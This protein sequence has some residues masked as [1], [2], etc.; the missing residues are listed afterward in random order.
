MTS[1]EVNIFNWIYDVFDCCDRMRGPFLM[2]AKK[3]NIEDMCQLQSRTEYIG[4]AE[5]SVFFVCFI[6]PPPQN[7][8]VEVQPLAKTLK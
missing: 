3:E 2:R 1:S 7:N 4:M 8:V 6:P 5:K